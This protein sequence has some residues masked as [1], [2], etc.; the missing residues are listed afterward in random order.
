M[1]SAIEIR[2]YEWSGPYA[3][4]RADAPHD[5][6]LC[7][8]VHAPWMPASERLILRT[9]EIVGDPEFYLYDDHFPPADP[10]GRGASYRHIPFRWDASRAPA[11]L[12]ADCEVPGKARFS[13]TLTACD[14]Y[15]DIRLRIVNNLRRRIGPIDW[16]FC[17]IALECPT[18]RDPQ[19]TRTF[20]FDGERLR[21][22]AELRVGAGMTLIPI[23]GGDDFGPALHA[24][25]PR[26]SVR[27]QASC[28]IL[29]SVDGK[30]C[31]ALA[32][33][34]AYSAFGCTGNMCF[35]AD[36]YFGVIDA[37]EEKS[38]K[39]RLYLMAGDRHAALSRYQREF[40]QPVSPP[41]LAR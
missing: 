37:G 30:H 16:A 8:D 20:I 14:D 38:M 22:F 9:S 5:P 18:L 36:P 6:G 34:Q 3:T 10:Q 31:A 39:G 26:S 19:H 40:A 29:E 33:T 17:S 27:A 41:V 12:I 11:Q 35:H 21:S 13:V 1:S 24:H 32:F 7:A 15:L 25:L 2:P 23:E 28:T 4:W